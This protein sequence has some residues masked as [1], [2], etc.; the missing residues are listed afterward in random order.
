MATKGI[1]SEE[2][3][4]TLT[5]LNKEEVAWLST[6]KSYIFNEFLT[7]IEDRKLC[8]DF[9]DSTRNTLLNS[10]LIKGA[11]INFKKC[12]KDLSLDTDP[13]YSVDTVT[14]TTGDTISLSSIPTAYDNEVVET[15]CKINGDNADFTFDYNTLEF[16]INDSLTNGDEINYGYIYSGEFEEDLIE[17]EIS[18]LALTMILSW[19]S[20][21]LYVTDKLRD[22]IL[23]KDFSQP[24]SPAN[25]VKELRLLREDA[26]REI[27]RAVVGYTK[28]SIDFDGYK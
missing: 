10:Y 1:I 27:R 28:D 8:Q 4:K 25:L 26:L 13:D 2:K 11:S 9:S 5:F 18:I 12:R 7:L 20:Y 21:N 3:W 16:T 17:E 24:H 22:T 23:S 19:T 6:P 15:F 14:Y